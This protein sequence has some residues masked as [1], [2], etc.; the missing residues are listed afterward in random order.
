MGSKVQMFGNRVWFVCFFQ[1]PQSRFALV[2]RCRVD[3][4]ARYVDEQYKL[5]MDQEL[6]C[7]GDAIKDTRVHAC[8]YFIAP[9]GHGLRSIDLEFMKV[10]HLQGGKPFARVLFS[11]GGGRLVFV[12]NIQHSLTMAPRPCAQKLHERVNIIPVIA[13]ADSM[14]KNEIA[15]F[16]Q[17]I[18]QVLV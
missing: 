2:Q 15:Q 8:L 4:V 11:L 1:E 13:K 14:T 18:R 6:Q 17:Q 5:F 3:R 12:S 7:H 10:G 9:T 16:K